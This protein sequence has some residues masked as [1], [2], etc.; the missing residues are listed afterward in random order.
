MVLF[1]VFSPPHV[2][3]HKYIS[4]L[5]HCTG[6]PSTA[7]DF[8]EFYDLILKI[9]GHAPTYV[10]PRTFV[11]RVEHANDEDVVVVLIGTF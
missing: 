10:L 11:L 9:E 8:L 6:M 7:L 5:A 3:L 1:T 4:I 2:L